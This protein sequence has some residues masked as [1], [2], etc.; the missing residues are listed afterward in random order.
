[1]GGGGLSNL[2]ARQPAP[3]RRHRRRAAAA[4]AG[5]RERLAGGGEAAG[6]LALLPREEKLAHLHGPARGQRAIENGQ[7]WGSHKVVQ[8]GQKRSKSGQT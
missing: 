3:P 4:A 2:K 6:R 1:M 7:A 5:R 8:S